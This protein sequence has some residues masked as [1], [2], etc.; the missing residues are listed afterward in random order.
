MGYGVVSNLKSSFTY[1]SLHVRGTDKVVKTRTPHIAW[2]TAGYLPTGLFSSDWSFNY[3]NADFQKT[4]VSVQRNGQPF[5]TKV[6]IVYKKEDSP[7]AGI[8]WRLIYDTFLSLNDG[9]YFDVAIKNVVVDGKTQDFTY[10]VTILN[11]TP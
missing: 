8:V 3:A 5:D 11:T 10:K 1:S 7:G 4:T 2:P 6:L 9:D